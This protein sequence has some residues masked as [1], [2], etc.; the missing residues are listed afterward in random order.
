M[1]QI[2]LGVTLYSFNVEYYTYRYT[3]EECMEAV[4][5][6]GS[7]QGVEIVGPQM[8]RGY[9]D[10]PAEFE[11]RFRRAIERYDLVPTAYGA[12]GDGQRMTDAWPTRDQQLD[13]LRRQIRAASRLGFP[14]IRVQP[15]EA[16]FTD[17]LDYADKYDVTMGIEIHA[18]MSIEELGPIR[19]RVEEIDSPRLGFVPDCG[20][21]C[22]SCAKVYVDRFLELGVRPDVVERILERWR[23]RTPMEEVA[24]EVADM[25]GNDY[26]DLMVIEST[27]YFGHSDPASLLSIMRRI[28][29]VHGKFFDI[30]DNGTDSAV[31]FPEVVAALHEGNY[32]G[33]ISCEYEGH[34]WYRERPAIEQLRTLQQSIQK[35]LK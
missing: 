29:H 20:T 19:E 5:S 33:Y 35:Q 15:S 16:V 23:T 14:V 17:L 30:D 2:K 9:P 26:A 1:S 6:L 25:G 8:I 3:L 24:H 21:F 27:I 11:Q 12:Y 32:D 22:H 34:H 28:V 7:G 13:Y 4:G 18:P 31:R 10:L